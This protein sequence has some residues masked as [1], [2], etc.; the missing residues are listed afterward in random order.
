MAD[1]CADNTQLV[2]TTEPNCLCA[3]E[4]YSCDCQPGVAEL[5]GQ[6]LDCEAALMRI[7]CDDGEEVHP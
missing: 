1:A 2:C 7:E 6:C 3:G 4:P 5:A